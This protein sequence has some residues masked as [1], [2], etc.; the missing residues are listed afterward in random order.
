MKSLACPGTLYSYG[1]RYTT[2]VR[3]KLPCG[4]GVGVCHSRVVD[5]H[6]LSELTFLP[7]FMLQ[8]K[9]KINGNCASPSAQAACEIDTFSRM[10]ESLKPPTTPVTFAAA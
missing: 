10:N 8:K 3:A 6:G 5:S 1:P 2:G 4:G 9:L 7:C